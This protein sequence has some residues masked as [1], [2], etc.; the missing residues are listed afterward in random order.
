MIAL[1]VAAVAAAALSDKESVCLKC[2][3]KFLSQTETDAE[4]SI[5][6]SKRDFV[7]SEERKENGRKYT[8]INY[9][10]QEKF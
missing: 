4:I 7:D 5:L 10:N 1:P 6:F 9:F 3:G 2:H 8:L